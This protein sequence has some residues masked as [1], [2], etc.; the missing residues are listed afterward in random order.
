[1][2]QNDGYKPREERSWDEFHPELDI[3]AEFPVFSADQIDGISPADS[4]PGTPING[5]S[6]GQYAVDSGLSAVLDGL[7]AQQT[8]ATETEDNSFSVN[9]SG[10]LAT[11]KRR[12]GRPPRNKD[13]MLSWIG[14]TASPTHQPSPDYES[15]REAELAEALCPTS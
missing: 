11:P 1:M 14:I 10:A 4:D 12:P 5:S 7:R 9:G 2:A 6:S 15:K 3:D 8:E 13:S